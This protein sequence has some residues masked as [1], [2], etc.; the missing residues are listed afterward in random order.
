V[1]QRLR[2][3]Y[4]RIDVIFGWH[5]DWQARPTLLS[6]AERKTAPPTGSAARLTA[7]WPAVKHERSEIVYIICIY[8]I[9]VVSSLM[10]FI[11]F[12]YDGRFEALHY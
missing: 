5:G 7:S 9:V 12:V 6:A 11:E 8:I 10:M 2:T 4:V 1:G 3:A